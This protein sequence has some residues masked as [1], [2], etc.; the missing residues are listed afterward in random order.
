MDNSERL[1]LRR[2]R[3]VASPAIFRGGFRPFFLG[4]GVWAVLA[5]TIWLWALDAGF[6]QIGAL[7]PLD[8]HRHEML[9][10]FVGAA[11]AGF[12]LTAVPNWTGHLPIAG[13]PLAGLA[14]WWL[15]ARLLPF[16]M[17]HAP[18]PVLAMLDG[19]FYLGLALLILRETLQARNL[20]LPIA[21]V[22]G[23]FG[24]ADI[25]DYLG[26]TGMVVQQLG[27]NL[28]IALATSLVV[29]IGGRIV[30]SFTRN[31]MQRKKL[32]GPLPGQ[33]DRFDFLV[34]TVTV[35]SLFAW[36]AAEAS[37]ITGSALLVAAVLQILRLSRWRG[38]RTATSPI[39]VVLH[40]AYAW[41]PIGLALLAMEGLGNAIPR[42]AGIHAL[43]AGA[44]ACMILAVMTRAILG[45]TGRA[46]AAD[47]PT[48]ACYL[49]I[50]LA[51]ICRVLA[52]LM[53]EYYQPLLHL[54]GTFWIFAFAS[55][56]VAY[57]P[58]LL[59]PRL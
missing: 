27:T 22:I 23:L 52:S 8:W 24:V 47:L 26:I 32:G 1:E 55:F 18:L 59:R 50:Q 42:S 16:A 9:F 3:A 11:I 15:A 4:A 2:Q 56:L 28:A 19:G 25:L 58:K 31:W 43:T 34:I 21:L 12:A 36:A 33:A 10:G 49:L 53:G 38:W 29:L 41:I 39:V 20:N 44:M 17:P 13:A 45:H 54:A 37:L 40:L 30:P 14:L 48:K 5:I 7:D 46:L 6:A 57:A 35:I 51:V